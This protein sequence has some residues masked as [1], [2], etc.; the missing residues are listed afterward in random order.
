MNEAEKLQ[1]KIINSDFFAL[2]NVSILAPDYTL[3]ES[4]WHLHVKA[5]GN[6][7]QGAGIFAEDLLIIDC[8]LKAVHGNVVLASVYGELTLKKLNFINGKIT[9]LPENNEYKAISITSDC[10]FSIIGVLKFNIHKHI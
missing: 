9:L 10:S 3:L 5:L 1:S 7:M 2:K 6:S 8:A 4:T